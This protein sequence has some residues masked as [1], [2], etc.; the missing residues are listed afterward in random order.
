VPYQL[1]RVAGDGTQHGWIYAKDAHGVEQIQSGMVARRQAEI[2]L[3]N[4]V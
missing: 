1:Y 3:W 4:R 2:D